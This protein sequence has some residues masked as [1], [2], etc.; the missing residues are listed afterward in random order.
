[1]LSFVLKSLVMHHFRAV[2]MI[3]LCD[4]L[5][6]K[7][8]IIIGSVIEILHINVIECQLILMKH[9]EFIFRNDYL[10]LFN[11]ESGILHLYALNIGQRIL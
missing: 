9:F 8:S 4:M 5:I 11:F 1:M 6:Q 2:W 3:S 7:K 10:D